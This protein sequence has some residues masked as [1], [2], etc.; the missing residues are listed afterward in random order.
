MAGRRYGVNGY[1]LIILTLSIGALSLSLIA[2]GTNAS[3][4]QDLLINL[5]V[6]PVT[7]W[8]YLDLVR[9]IALATALNTRTSMQAMFLGLSILIGILVAAPLLWPPTEF[10]NNVDHALFPASYIS[11]LT[12]SLTFLESHMSLSALLG[13]VG[14]HTSI[15]TLALILVRKILLYRCEKH[16]DALA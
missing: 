15:Y 8:L 6:L 2:P 11:R 9:W 16:L 4:P 7:S 5:L 12:G 1:M 10:H 13:M 14:I 3:I